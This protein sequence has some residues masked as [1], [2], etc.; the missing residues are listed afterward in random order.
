M[1]AFRRAFNFSFSS[2]TPVDTLISEY[3]S[4]NLS[5]VYV[6][7]GVFSVDESGFIGGVDFTNFAIESV[8][9][10]ASAPFMRANNVWP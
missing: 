7:A 9:C 1:S 6:P 3:S 2:V 8:S 4:K 5:V 10:W